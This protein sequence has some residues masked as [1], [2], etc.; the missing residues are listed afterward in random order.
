MRLSKLCVGITVNADGP[1][2]KVSNHPSFKALY[3][4]ASILMRVSTGPVND[5]S[6]PGTSPVRVIYFS[7]FRLSLSAPRRGFSK[8][9]GK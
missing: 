4:L 1:S 3:Y 9:K 8:P 2:L 7:H 6:A 5:D